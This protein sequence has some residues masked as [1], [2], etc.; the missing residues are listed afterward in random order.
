MQ[1]PKMYSLFTL[2]EAKWSVSKKKR[3]K[4]RS[5]FAV[6]RDV[7]LPLFSQAELDK[8]RSKNEEASKVLEELAQRKAEAETQVRDEC[9]KSH[10]SWT[11]EALSI[12]TRSEG[13]LWGGDARVCVCEYLL[14]SDGR[15]EQVSTDVT[16]RGVC[17]R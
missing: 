5:V 7:A 1:S 8:Q 6:L 15:D 17:S 3:T 13:T 2:Q 11:A 16:T 9:F 14:N 10:H 12:Q 4:V